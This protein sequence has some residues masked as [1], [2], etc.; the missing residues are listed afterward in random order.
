MLIIN[1]FQ[2][3]RSAIL[4]VSRKRILPVLDS[5][6]YFWFFQPWTWEAEPLRGS[7]YCN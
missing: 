2:T 1:S 4:K 6:F 7:D 3:A 5:A